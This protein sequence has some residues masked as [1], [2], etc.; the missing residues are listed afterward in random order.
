[1]QVLTPVLTF[2]AGFIVGSSLIGWLTL[3]RIQHIVRVLE[4]AQDPEP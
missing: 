2:A 3:R 4:V 1:M